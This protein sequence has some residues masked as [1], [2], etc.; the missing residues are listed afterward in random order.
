MGADFVASNLAAQGVKLDV[1]EV[2][3]V[4]VA[5]L[6]QFNPRYVLGN[7]VQEEP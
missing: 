7:F 1:P 6:W 5:G 4:F 3:L 2:E